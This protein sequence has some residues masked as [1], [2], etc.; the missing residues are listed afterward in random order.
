MERRSTMNEITL[1]DVA[2]LAGCSVNTVSLALKDSPRI[3][4]K[5]K[6]RVLQVA[7][8]LEYVPNNLARSLVLG[9]TRTI[10]L[11]LRNISSTTLVS[12]ARRIEQYLSRLDYTLS[13]MASQDDP[14]L[15]AKAI[16]VM[17]SN[18][19][20][21]ILLNTAFPDNL[22]K[23]EKLRESGYPILLVSGFLQSGVK[24]DAIYPDLITGSYLATK[25]LTDMGHRAVAYVSRAK[26]REG[27]MRNNPK[28]IGFRKALEDAG[29]PFE[30]DSIANIPFEN[31]SELEPAALDAFLAHVRHLTAVFM[32]SDEAGIPVMKMMIENG[33]RIPED[34]AVTSIDN[35]RFAESAIVGL[36]SVG[37]DI[38]YM[39]E[40]SVDMLL[41]IINGKKIAGSFSNIP[42]PPVMHVRDSCGAR[43][44][45][46]DE[47][48][49]RPFS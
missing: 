1:K 20:D 26:T 36:T 49:R 43:R 2:R 10:G 34:V 40:H 48:L 46:G 7:G 44:R 28:I 14:K 3:S 17:L 30:G 32:D 5:T 47:G 19:V 9:K 24:A 6:E 12:E 33:I 25:H 39:A 4:A 21:G 16:N 11:I 42:V 31:L 45:G 22:A 37:Y 41:E 15:E 13:I 23:V 18:K 8:E 35:I 38:R 29:I 27:T